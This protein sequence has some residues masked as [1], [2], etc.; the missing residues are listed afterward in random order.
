MFTLINYCVQKCYCCSPR[1]NS[2]YLARTFWRHGTPKARSIV[3]HLL[4][5]QQMSNW[6][7]EDELPSKQPSHLWR[8]SWRCQR[9]G[10]YQQRWWQWR[11]VVPPYKTVGSFREF[12]FLKLS[13][14][15]FSI[16]R[17]GSNY[18]SFE[19]IEFS[20]FIFLT[21]RFGYSCWITLLIKSLWKNIIL[22]LS[23]RLFV[24]W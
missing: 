17:V 2:I 13:S 6:C 18:G 16:S 11:P 5:C 23:P 19:F 22:S 14:C 24:F 7:H 9:S 4:S 15:L 21:T 10:V 8:A 1:S 12:C 3:G 20:H